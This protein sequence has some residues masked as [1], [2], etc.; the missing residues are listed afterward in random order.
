MEPGESPPKRRKGEEGYPGTPSVSDYLYPQ[1]G[2]NFNNTPPVGGGG[3]GGGVTYATGNG[4]GGGGGGSQHTSAPGTP[5]FPAYQTPDNSQ[6]SFNLPDTKP[7]QLQL[8]AAQYDMQQQQPP[9]QQQQQQHEQFQNYPP[10]PYPSSQTPG[11]GFISENQNLQSTFKSEESSQDSS[12]K[13][14]FP[15]SASS[16]S[17]AQG[18]GVGGAGYNCTPTSPTT[19]PLWNQFMPNSGYPASSAAA[20]TSNINTGYNNLPITDGTGSASG[21]VTGSMMSSSTTPYSTNQAPVSN[22]NSYPGTAAAAASGAAGDSNGYPSP[23]SSVMPNLNSMQMN[24]NPVSSALHC[25]SGAGYYGQSHESAAAGLGEPF[26]SRSPA[27]IYSQHNP[28][29]SPY[30]DSRKQLS[31]YSPYNGGGGMGGYP[32]M[33]GGY[34]GGMIKQ[35]PSYA[36]MNHH[37]VGGGLGP[38]YGGMP[39]YPPHPH[40]GAGM[41]GGPGAGGYNH[42]PPHHPHH[43]HPHHMPPAYQYIPPSPSLPLHEQYIQIEMRLCQALSHVM[44]GPPVTHIY[45][46]LDYAIE[47]HKCYLSKYCQTKKDI[48]FLGM[49]PGP[50]G[51]AQTGV[52]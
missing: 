1:P 15:N 29:S 32:G 9:S 8:D 44:F 45:N 40:H 10:N 30:S 25:G 26:I 34:D 48:L 17:C 33:G 16:S 12:C 11:Q 52:S 23:L 20:T 18:Q 6:T 36:L 46:P 35:E 5:T 47:P 28:Y 39:G 22:L 7:T 19:S 13:E 43:H 14:E 3:T 49:N 51:M 31:P 2:Y 24:H 38:G 41:Y 37:G 42:F 27:D 50:Y 4:G 21:A